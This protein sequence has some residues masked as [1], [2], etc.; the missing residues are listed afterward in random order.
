MT[1][2]SLEKIK[3][4][5]LNNYNWIEYEYWTTIIEY[6]FYLFPFTLNSSLQLLII[7]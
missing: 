2:F 4:K 6:A 5:H 3:L 1:E 7:N